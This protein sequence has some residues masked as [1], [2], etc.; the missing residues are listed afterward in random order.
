[1]ELYGRKTIYTRVERITR[2]NV[3][4]VMQKAN[5]AFLSN[6]RQIQ[7]LYNYYKGK[8]PVLQRIKEIRPEICN[9][10]VENRALEIVSFKT[11]YLR[12]TDPVYFRER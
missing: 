12:R 9:K 7:Y 2:E 10:I 11:V 4:Q 3:T 6:Q 5:S 1:M 8:Q